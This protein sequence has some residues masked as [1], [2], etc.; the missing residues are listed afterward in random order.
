[1][2]IRTKS[3]LTKEVDIEEVKTIMEDLMNGKYYSNEDVLQMDLEEELN[4]K[5]GKGNWKY[6]NGLEEVKDKL[7]KF[8]FN[9][10]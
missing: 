8:K 4:R 5:Y 1:M 9:W 2:K 3:I 6:N 7:V 10:R